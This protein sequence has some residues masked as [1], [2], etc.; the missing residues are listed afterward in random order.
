MSS[1]MRILMMVALLKKRNTNMK[2][3]SWAVNLGT[4]F[5]NWGSPLHVYGD[6]KLIINALQGGYYPRFHQLL[7]YHLRLLKAIDIFTNPLHPYKLKIY[8]YYDFNK[9]ASPQKTKK[10]KR[11]K[12]SS[13]N[14]SQPRVLV[15]FLV[16]FGR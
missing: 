9:R 12:K 2:L 16:D 7:P 11:N 8:F 3:L 13:N 15:E 6:F 4:E 14:P 1:K 5:G 10:R